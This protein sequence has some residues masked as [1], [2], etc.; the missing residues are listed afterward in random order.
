[1]TEAKYDLFERAL[2][3]LG[4]ALSQVD[5]G[6]IDHA[7]RMLANAKQ[8][9]VYG[10]GREALQINGFAMRLFH[11][12][13][14][15][16]V[17]GDMT[18]PALGEGDVFL[19]SSGPGETSTVL[20]L[21]KVAHDAGAK[22]LLVTAAAKSSAG[23]SCRFHAD[24]SGADHGRRSGC[25]KTSVLPMGS[26]FEGALFLLFEV[27]VLRLKEARRL[28]G[29]H[30]RPAYEHG[31]AMRYELMLPHQIRMAIAENWPVVL[32]LGV[33][34]YHGE[35][36][37]V[38]MDTL[39][40][41]KMLDLIEAEMAIVI[42]PPFYY[43]AASYAVE[44]PEGNGSV[45]VGGR[46]LAPFAEGLFFSLL[47]DRLSQH[48]RDHPSPDREFRRRNADGPRVQVGGAAGGLPFHGKGER[49]GLVGQ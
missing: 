44:P 34:E 35:H 7:C 30:A 1:M 41:I 10:C 42:L 13:L 15:V 36:M 22:N 8:I 33:L 39:A 48:P 5:T 4:T 16:S 2:S 20:T 18:M 38:G 17:V 29:S 14:P 32:P 46:R 49:R 26:V 21:M 19:A 43:G 25:A 9:I 47:R 6:A 3:E 45:Q 27:M 40:V 11:L 28:A 31:I 23:E 37:A 24:H 12:G